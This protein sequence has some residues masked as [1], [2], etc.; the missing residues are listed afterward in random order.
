MSSKRIKP[1]NRLMH[2]Q[3]LAQQGQFN[4]AAEAF[5]AILATKP[6][7]LDAMFGL[8]TVHAMCG[9][10]HNAIGLLREVIQAKPDH[11][12]AL[13]NL[14][15]A[16]MQQ[17]SAHEAEPLFRALLKLKPDSAPA[18]YG[19]GCA[20]QQLGNATEAEH[21]YRKALPAMPNEPG[22]WMNLATALRQQ[23]RL[24][25]AA[26]AYQK[27]TQL[28]PDLMQAWSALGQ[29]LLEL[30]RLQDSEHAFRNAMQLAPHQAEA[31]IGLSDVLV[32]QQ[33]D[34]AALNSYLRAIELDPTSQNAHTKIESLLLRLASSRNEEALLS[35]MSA[36]RICASP[37]DAKSDAL[38]LLAAY[39]YP[40]TEVLDKTRLFLE[41]FE[42]ER[43]Y[44]I[45]WWQQ[46]LSAFGTPAKGHDKILR[47]ICSIL[48]SW[49]V[50]SK[51]AIEA[52]AN[53]A[54]NEAIHSFGAGT[55]YWEWLLAKHYGTKIVA[56]DRE[57]RHRYIEMT[58]E[59]YATAPVREGEVVF[60]AWVPR[61]V[62]VVMNLLQQMRPG[63][64]LVLVGQ[65]PDSAGKARI[66]ATDAFFHH[67]E[68]RYQRMA[69]IKLGCYSY[70]Q[71]DVRLYQRL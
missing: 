7:H 49:S 21:C 10:T 44:T 40:K 32:A 6:N 35:R 70:I 48:Y 39:S 37:A 5:R 22:L 66:C 14:S 19:L 53:F 34:D 60:L 45:D 36:N 33:H 43:L 58:E 38:A 30:N 63:Q 13:L 27:T 57:L 16:L 51:E 47:G 24:A 55:G 4:Q 26:D 62:T 2:A 28:K 17:G 9:Q 3:R 23:G 61:G 59:D 52:V 18:I 12:A 71:D 15:N 69:T 41:C 50:P 11:P 31:V 25:D 67:L 42:P 8:A 29:T 54:G 65:G 1:D 64:K 68:T 20:L 46:Q 56:G